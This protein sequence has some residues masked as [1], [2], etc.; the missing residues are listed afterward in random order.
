[1]IGGF[2]A[3][4]GLLI[5]NIDS[6]SN[7]LPAKCVGASASLFLFAIGLHVLKRYLAALVLSGMAVIREMEA[8]PIVE[9]LNFDLVLDQLE[10][11]TFW[12]ARILVRRNIAKVRD[13]D[14]AAG[15]RL[16]AKLA[17]IQGYFVLAQMI[18]VVAAAQVL[19]RAL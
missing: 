13:G 4:L 11:S 14:F 12:P 18:I 1:M 15:G 16:Y 19:A 6:V 3:I 17:Q 2:A 10:R 5:S 7:I 8:Q 9:G